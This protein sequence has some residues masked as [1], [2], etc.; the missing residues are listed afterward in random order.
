[1]IILQQRGKYGDYLPKSIFTTEIWV[2]NRY[3][4]MLLQT[5][6]HIGI[7]KDKIPLCTILGVLNS[8]SY[9]E[10]S[11]F[12]FITQILFKTAL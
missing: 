7:L 9:K 8:Q 6:T 5:R 1:M 10:I 3:T 11:K 2:N 4:N 12:T